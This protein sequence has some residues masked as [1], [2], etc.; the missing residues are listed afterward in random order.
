MNEEVVEIFISIA[1]KLS[2]AKGHISE[3]LDSNPEIYLKVREELAD[4]QELMAKFC[5]CAPIK[6]IAGQRDDILE[7]Y[8]SKNIN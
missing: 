6:L 8:H 4:C 3:L 2:F 7:N 1:Q 5:D